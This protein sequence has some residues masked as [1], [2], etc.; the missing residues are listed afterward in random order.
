MPRNYTVTAAAACQRKTNAVKKKLVSK[1]PALINGIDLSLD[2]RG[3]LLY[4]VHQIQKV[5]TL[6]QL[7]QFEPFRTQYDNMVHTPPSAEM[8]NMRARVRKLQ[9]QVE[10]LEKQLI[11]AHQYGLACRQ[12]ADMHIEL[13]ERYMTRFGDIDQYEEEDSDEIE[14]V[15][16]DDD[17]GDGHP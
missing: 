7:V 9:D 12:S 16:Y 6:D 13:V 5:L 10:S 4:A 14:L 1:L 11:E 8:V 17:K 15:D 2:E 3:R